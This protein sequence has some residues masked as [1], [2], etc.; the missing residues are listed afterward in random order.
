LLAL[1]KRERPAADE[2]LKNPL[3]TAKL[4]K[5]ATEVRRK[6]MRGSSENRAR[7]NSRRST[8]HQKVT[9]GSSIKKKTQKGRGGNAQVD[10][11]SGG[12][13]KDGSGTQTNGITRGNLEANVGTNR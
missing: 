13:D 8:L 4:K 5:E 7:Q 1:A 10:S 9:S 2:A 12:N 3:P 11:A 6:K